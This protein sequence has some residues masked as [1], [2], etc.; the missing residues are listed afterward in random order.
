MVEEI[1]HVDVRYRRADT[2]VSRS[3]YPSMQ[4]YSPGGIKDEEIRVV[5]EAIRH[6]VHVISIIDSR[7][8]QFGGAGVGGGREDGGWVGC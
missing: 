1:T 3:Q 4:P 7:S 5:R 8:R 6:V 2:R